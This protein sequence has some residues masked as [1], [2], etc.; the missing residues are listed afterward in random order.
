LAVGSFKPKTVECADAIGCEIARLNES[1]TGLKSRIV[2]LEGV[3]NNH[4]RPGA[5]GN[6][7]R[8]IVV[9]RIR[10]V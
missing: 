8:E 1:P 10:V 6:E 2:G 3:R 9:I 5:P 4:V 7:I